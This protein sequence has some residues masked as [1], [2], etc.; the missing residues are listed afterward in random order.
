MSED[1]KLKK[2]IKTTILEFV[3][4]NNNYIPKQQ[5]YGGFVS[6]PKAPTKLG[7][8]TPFMSTNIVGRDDDETY[9]IRYYD[10]FTDD[11]VCKLVHKL[12]D[13]TSCNII[14]SGSMVK[15]IKNNGD[16]IGYFEVGDEVFIYTKYIKNMKMLMRDIFPNEYQEYIEKHS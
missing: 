1:K 12:T 16:I 7:R 3:N 11:M 9:N 13:E 6:H 5:P 8:A 4:E 15:P 10:N 2:F 14:N